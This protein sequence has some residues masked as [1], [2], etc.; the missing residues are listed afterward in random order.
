MEPPH[1]RNGDA[2]YY[3]FL[4]SILVSKTKLSSSA[5]EILLLLVIRILS[6]C[7]CQAHDKMGD[8][9]STFDVSSMAAFC[10]IE[11]LVG[12]WWLRHPALTHGSWI[13]SFTSFK[14]KNWNLH[15]ASSLLHLV[16]EQSWEEYCE[17]KRL[18]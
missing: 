3:I 8:I 4:W 10:V 12:D 1:L 16:A 9:L 5:I 13:E 11:L 18:V 15:K 14:V 7:S 17:Y 2:V 6:L